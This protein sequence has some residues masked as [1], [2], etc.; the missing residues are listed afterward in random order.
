MDPGS[1][2]AAVCRIPHDLA[3]RADKSSLDLLRAAG[4][5][6]AHESLTEADL[7]AVF[8]ADPHLMRGWSVMGFDGRSGFWMN[9]PATSGNSSGEWTIGHPRGRKVERF[10]DGPSACARYA[11][12]CIEDWRSMIEGGRPIRRR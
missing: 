3:S 7:R 8:E 9:P 12:L 6:D 10:P 11:K 1:V 2:A 4:Y 5:L